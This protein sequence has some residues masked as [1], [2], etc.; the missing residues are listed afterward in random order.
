VEDS[1]GR[2]VGLGTGFFVRPDLVATALH[3]VRGATRVNA[4]VVTDGRPTSVQGLVALDP[5]E[6]LAL[7]RVDTVGSPLALGHERDVAVGDEI[8]VVGNPFGLEGS[9]SVGIVS[10]I[11]TLDSKTRLQVTAPMSPGN[12]GGPIVDSKGRVVGIAVSQVAAGQNV[13]FAIPS[14]IAGCASRESGTGGCVSG[15]GPGATHTAG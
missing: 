12:S 4:R 7:L 8:Y 2:R 6:D 1:A 13:N 11:R 3:V 15:T 9:I 10:G 14:V 5:G